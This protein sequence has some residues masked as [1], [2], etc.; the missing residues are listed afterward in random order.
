MS[1]GQLSEQKAML[2]AVVSE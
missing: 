2:G 1:C